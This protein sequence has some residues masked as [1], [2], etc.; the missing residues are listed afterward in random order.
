MYADNP[1]IVVVKEYRVPTPYGQKAYRD[2]DVTAVDVTT[3]KPVSLHQTGVQKR[4]LPVNREVQA[5]DDIE[6]A[7]GIRP[8]FHN[9]NWEGY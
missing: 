2:V 6:G 7:T 9:Y 8:Q 3:G 4:G 5:I 1:N